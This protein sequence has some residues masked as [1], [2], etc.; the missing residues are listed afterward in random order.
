MVHR[1]ASID[2]VN[3]GRNLLTNWQLFHE[4][5]STADH[6]FAGENELMAASSNR[7]RPYN[8]ITQTLDRIIQA[9]RLDAEARAARAEG[10]KGR[11]DAGVTAGTANPP[12][13]FSRA[14]A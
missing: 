8:P 13:R 9:E 1:G 6:F 7:V 12:E 3:A 4:P 11:G 10:R 2:L 14:R 5:M